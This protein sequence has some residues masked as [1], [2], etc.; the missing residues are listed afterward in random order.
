MSDSFDLLVIGAGTAGAGAAR[1]AAAAGWRTAIV[2]FR[3]YGGT[4]ALRGCDP[5]KM[6]RRG[7]E[8]IDAARLMAGKGIV[9]DDLRIDWPALMAHK[10]SFTDPV[11]EKMEKGLSKAG[12]TTFHGTARFEDGN[13]V[14]ID[15]GTRI[16]A[17]HFLLA[18]GA[19]PRPLD[20][21]GA[22]HVIDSTA[23]MELEDL[24]R[25]VVFVGGGYVSMEFAHIAAR[26]GAE[27]TV[28]DRGP[29]PLMAF[30][31]D[32]VA[33][34]VARSKALDITFRNDTDVGSIRKEDSGYEVELHRAEGGGKEVVGCDLVV[35]GA[36]R[37]A[38]L[39]QLEPDRAG[40]DWSERG[41]KVHPH[42][43]SCSHADVYAAGDCADTPGAP[44]TPVSSLESGIAASN[45][46]EGASEAP[47]YRGIPSA[48][49]TVPEL[50]RVG[51]GEEE[52]RKQG[53]DCD[54]RFNDTSGWFSQ[55]R[56]GETHAATKL[57]IEKGSERILGAH[58]LGPEYAEVVNTIG[59][60]IRLDL[61]AGDL[62]SMISAYPSTGSDLGSM[63]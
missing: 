11:P 53:L 30:D 48:V 25:R 13:S 58:L 36:G 16:A 5:K 51:L 47:D 41:V 17:R 24:P 21:P 43:Q 12:I 37:I 60:A 9:G 62:K 32:L 8:I 33:L 56:V 19:R 14:R 38:D 59:L 15:D 7:A 31:G 23:F 50:V 54:V 34:L 44:L 22:E 29:R 63:L 49:F 20:M 57:I 4:C 6:L 26:A 27:V 10:R 42:L 2:D 28:V 1:R 55:R 46:L 39:A 45:M 35:H 61:K 3:P 52:A 40:I 18:T